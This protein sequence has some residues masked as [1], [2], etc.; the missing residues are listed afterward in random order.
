MPVWYIS[1]FRD[2]AICSNDYAI[3]QT[4]QRCKQATSKILQNSHINSM[5]MQYAQMKIDFKN[6]M[7]EIHKYAICS[8][9]NSMTENYKNS[10]KSAI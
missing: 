5:T 1:V 9:E 7:T 4:V 8:N 2:Y 3:L 10:I 6:S